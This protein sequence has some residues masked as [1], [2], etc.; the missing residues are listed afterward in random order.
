M[1]RPRKN[2][3]VPGRDTLAE[4]VARLSHL[5]TKERG[6]LPKAYLRDPGLRTA[7]LSYFLPP[8]LDKIGVPLRE[9]S[10]HPAKLLEQEHLQVLDLGS[11]PGTAIL[12][13]RQFLA[14]NRMRMRLEC[15]AVDQVGENLKDAEVLFREQSGVAGMPATLFTVRSGIEA[16]AEHSGGPFDIIV[17]SNVLNELYLREEDR[18]NK[19]TALVERLLEQL[20]APE[21]SCIIIEPALRDTSRDLLLVR[22]GIADAGFHVYSPCLVQGH[23]PALVNPKDWCHEDRPWDPPETIQEIDSCIGL[24]KDSLKFSYVV[25]RKDGRTLADA[26]GPG[27]F[28]VVSEPLI[29]KGKHELYLCGREG[30]RLAVRLDKDAAPGNE[31]FAQLSRGEVVRIEGLVI[32]EKRFRI[33]KDAKVVPITAFRQ[34]RVAPFPRSR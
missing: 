14:R 32:E 8:N 15:T 22:D 28:R 7:Y 13:I 25:L 27:C 21:G 12:G 4:D 10:L 20:L 30:R 5:L 6:S 23:C 2:R 18:V 31:A 3:T 26:C 16:I 1:A 11:G 24:R 29:S 19:R 17:L 9:L 33:S 34:E